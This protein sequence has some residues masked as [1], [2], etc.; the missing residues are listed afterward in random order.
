MTTRLYRPRGV[1]F[2]QSLGRTKRSRVSSDGK[3]EAIGIGE[4]GYPS[5]SNAPEAKPGHFVGHGKARILCRP[6]RID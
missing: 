2:V 4:S 6:P 5:V 1:G 3:L